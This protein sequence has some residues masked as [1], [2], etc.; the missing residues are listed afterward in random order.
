MAVIITWNG[1]NPFTGISQ[2]PLLARSEETIRTGTN[3]ARADVFTLTGKLQRDGCEDGFEAVYNLAKSLTLKFARNFS[4]FQIIE[5]GD[6]IF[7]YSRAIVESIS[8][9]ENR[10]YDLV[11]FTIRILCYQDSYARTYGILD[12]QEEF[13]F[14]EEEGCLVSISH[15]I[16]AR[17]INATQEALTNARNFVSTLAGY[18]GLTLP[19]G[20]S[21]T[22]VVLI[23]KQENV[24]RLTGEV[25]LTENYLYDKAGNSGNPAYIVTFQIESSIAD[26]IISVTASGKFQGALDGNITSTRTNFKLLDFY[27]V[28]NDE[29]H[30]CDP[31]TNLAI[32][33]IGFTADDNIDENSISFSI[34]YTNNYT[35]D[36]YVIDSTTITRDT[37]GIHCI[38]TDLI[39]RSDVGCPAERLRKTKAYL[40]AL[41]IDAYIAVKWATYGTG[42]RLGTTPQA[43]T[44]SFDHVLGTVSINITY[45]SDSVEDCGCIENMKYSLSFEPAIPQFSEEPSFQ[46]AGCYAIQNLQHNSRS[47][48]TISG[49]ARPSKCCTNE[50]VRSQIYSRAV[51]AMGKYFNAGDIV[52]EQASVEI[53]TDR[54][55]MSFTFA[56]NGLQVSGLSNTYVFATF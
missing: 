56:W 12:P 27:T 13:Q 5:D 23:K 50:A 55:V 38:T 48:F 1:Q 30:T 7:T 3:I 28:S 22:Q 39:I 11:P 37:Q 6:V 32:T 15:T 14:Q 42:K 41:D 45:C 40:A 21:P 9:D 18:D 47:R 34:T 43:K 46:G 2:T 24:N 4:L 17:G 49:T 52:L 25:S 44:I 16:S 29:F 54:S 33:P 19:F 8:F 53:A 10:Y 26:G 20:Y 35:S 31:L 51:Q 36:P